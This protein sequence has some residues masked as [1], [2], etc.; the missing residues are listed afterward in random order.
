LGD[1]GDLV[2]GLTEEDIH[3][4]KRERM[5]DELGGLC[6]SLWK[7]LTWLHIKWEEFKTLYGTSEEEFAL[8]NAVAPN[9]FGRLEQILWGDLMLHIS[10][11]TDPPRSAGKPNLSL[12]QL[13]LLIIEPD[14]KAEVE[15]LVTA[16]VARSAFARDW[17]NR[18]LAH[19]DLEHTKA[20]SLHS[21]APASRQDV[22]EALAEIREPVNVVEIHFEGPPPTRFERS[23]PS[24]QG[25]GALLGF[26][27][28][29]VPADSRRRGHS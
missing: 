10:R 22:T 4:R 16:A 1:E 15:S 13:P 24:P 9:F 11:L 20:P 2:M 23:I 18:H 5:G 17:R 29:N 12:N 6:F 21:L 27:R 28:R 19:S 14:L 25:V 3:S 7:E 26:M 8:M